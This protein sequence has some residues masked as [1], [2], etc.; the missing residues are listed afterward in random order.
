[1][2]ELYGSFFAFATPDGAI[3]EPFFM[4]DERSSQ[5]FSPEKS[6]VDTREGERLDPGFAIAAQP[7]MDVHLVFGDPVIGN[8]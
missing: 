7:E 3:A 5:I 4:S 8:A 1:M 6:L 2:S